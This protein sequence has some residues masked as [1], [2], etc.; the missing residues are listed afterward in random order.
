MAGLD[1]ARVVSV[2]A[3]YPW[4]QT[5]WSLEGSDGKPGFGSQD[6]PRFHVVAYDFGVKRNILR[7]L[8]AARLPCDGGAGADAGP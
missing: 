5:E 3:P 2:K 6:Q 1:L 8:A 7:M 4:T